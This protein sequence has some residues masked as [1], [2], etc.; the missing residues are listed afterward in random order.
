MCRRTALCSVPVA[1]V[2]CRNHHCALQLEYCKEREAVDAIMR[3]IEAEDALDAHARATKQADTQAFI[4]A[5]LAQ[6]Q[7][8]RCSCGC[9]QPSP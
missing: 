5:F 3:R 2:Q 7:R 6:Q 1:N 8:I 4:A 9:P